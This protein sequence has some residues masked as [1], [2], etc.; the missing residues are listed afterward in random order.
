MLTRLF[1]PKRIMMIM[2]SE[3]L[4]LA[5][6]IIAPR[7]GLGSEHSYAEDLTAQGRTVVARDK[8]VHCPGCCQSTNK[9]QNRMNRQ[10]LPRHAGEA[11]V[12]VFIGDV[13]E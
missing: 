9:E 1:A 8:Q 2:A 6:L 10:R 11:H 12:A 13:E 7:L 3:A 5:G 4:L